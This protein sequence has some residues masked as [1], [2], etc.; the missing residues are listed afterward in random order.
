MVTLLLPHVLDHVENISSYISWSFLRI[1]SKILLNGSKALL[2]T[3]KRAQNDDDDVVHEKIRTYR[4]TCLHCSR[5]LRFVLRTC[6]DKRS[7][8]FRTRAIGVCTQVTREQR[9][10]EARASARKSLASTLKNSASA[11]A[12]ARNF[13]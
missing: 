11:R 7:R 10:C 1:L 5:A 2:A 4:G 9:L 3:Q 13:M 6:M 12:S 8:V